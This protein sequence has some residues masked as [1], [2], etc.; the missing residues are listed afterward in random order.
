MASNGIWTIV[1]EDKKIVKKNG[2][3]SGTSY[4]INDNNFWNQSKFNNIWAI[5]YVDGSNSDEVEYRDTTPHST[6]T[7]ANIG[8]ITEFTSK[9]DTAHLAYLQGEWDKNNEQVEDPADSGTFRDETEAEK[10]ARLG[11]RPTSYTS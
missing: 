1:F 4:V 9:W 3:E 11:A 5:Q 7:E 8:A 6:F 10:I 2:L